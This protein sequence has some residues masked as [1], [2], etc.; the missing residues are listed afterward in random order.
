MRAP[1][2]RDPESTRRKILEAAFDEFYKNGFQGSS[3]NRIVEEAGATKG[4]LFHHFKGKNDVGYAVVR[5]IIYP[6]LKE[7]WAEPLVHSD[8][9]I[10]TLKRVLRQYLKEEMDNGQLVHG[11][12]LNNLAQEMSPLDEKFRQSLE[13]I[14]ADWRECLATAFARGIKVDKV[15]KNVSPHQVAAF[16]VAAQT[17]MMGLAKNAQD[18]AL[19]Q[20][21]GRALFDYLD[22]LK[23]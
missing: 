15:R 9:P 7:R 10:T 21:T 11:C 20:E 2:A 5:E 17:G 22:S 12:P 13:K 1:P 6:K 14:Y 23:P 8:D 18:E 19:L 3:I 4:A 16:I